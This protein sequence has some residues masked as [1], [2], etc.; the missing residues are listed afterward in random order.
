[1]YISD[2]SCIPSGLIYSYKH[3][4]AIISELVRAVAHTKLRGKLKLGHIF[5]LNRSPIDNIAHWIGVS[6]SRT[7]DGSSSSHG[8]S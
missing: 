3:G 1:M 5:Y 4:G 7:K 8:A 6:G 2:R